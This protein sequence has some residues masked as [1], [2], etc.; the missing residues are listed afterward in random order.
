M[1]LFSRKEEKAE[2]TTEAVEAAPK[3]APKPVVS[4]ALPTDRNLAS[5]LVKPRITEKAVGQGNSNVYTFIIRPD[6]TKHDVKDAVKALYN[7][8][9]VKVNI[10]KKAPRQFMSRSRGRK[11]G[12]KGMK[13]AY[14]YLKQGDSISV[15]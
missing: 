12:E 5:V 10:V 13:K 9:P 8:T 3:A 4:K 6:A 11:I 14:V 2:A 15:V 7:V 1:A